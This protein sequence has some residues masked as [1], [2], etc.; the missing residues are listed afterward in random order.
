[1]IKGKSHFLPGSKKKIQAGLKNH[2]KK[3][4]NLTDAQADTIRTLR[5]KHF[6]EAG[7]LMH[8][9]TQTRSQ[10]FDMMTEP[11]KASKNTRDNLADS[12]ASQFKEIEQLLY[13]HI[14]EVN[15]VLDE[16]QQPKFEQLMKDTFIHRHNRERERKRQ[17]R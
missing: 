17:G 8:E 15:E 16:E 5:R 6:R 12:I 4:L 3:E 14:S 11:G 9:L 7:A 13:R 2:M 10:Y 1:M